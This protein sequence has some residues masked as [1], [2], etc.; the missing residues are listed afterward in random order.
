MTD[1]CDDLS[2]DMLQYLDPTAAISNRA[3]LRASRHAPPALTLEQD[4]ADV[5]VCMPSDSGARIVANAP[6]L[7]Q[8]EQVDD[9]AS[10]ANKLFPNSFRIA[11][12]K[13]ICD[14]MLGAVLNSLPQKLV[15]VDLGHNFFFFDITH[16]S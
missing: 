6:G 7:P 9:E 13:H 5:L 14:N 3:A 15:R 4:T 12:L 1:L 2:M 8:E 11:G 16:D 10:T